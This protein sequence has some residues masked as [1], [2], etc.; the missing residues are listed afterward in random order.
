MPQP[1]R[2]AILGAGGVGGLV[3]A[4]LAREGAPVTLV[5]RAESLSRY[6]EQLQLEST[7]GNFTVPVSR[8]AT[9]PVVDVLWVTVKATQLEESLGAI[10]APALFRADCSAAERDRSPQSAA[11]AIRRGQSCSS[12]NRG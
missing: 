5:V 7:F 9:V 3:G 10:T 2:H 6:P 1:L 8:S 11:G 12:H 4:C